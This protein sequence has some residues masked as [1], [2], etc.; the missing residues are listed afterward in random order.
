VTL[1]QRQESDPKFRG[2]PV[3]VQEYRTPRIFA[4]QLKDTK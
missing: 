1:V 3:N 2:Q 4:E